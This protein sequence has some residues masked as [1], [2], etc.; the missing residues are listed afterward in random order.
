M[1]ARP[2]SR[3]R[4]QTRMQWLSI[5]NAIIALVFTSVA[6]AKPWN[7]RH[8]RGLVDQYIY[9]SRPRLMNRMKWYGI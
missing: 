1:V 7:P 3:P 8:R 2:E 6:N 4:L 9:V 5:Y